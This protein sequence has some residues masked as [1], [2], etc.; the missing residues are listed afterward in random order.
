[1]LSLWLLHY[2]GRGN[3]FLGL[4]VV[5]L[6]S[7]FYLWF[8]SFTF[9]YVSVTKLMLS[10]RLCQ[11]SL[12]MGAREW[13]C[14]HHTVT[15]LSVCVLIKPHHRVPRVSGQGHATGPH[16]AQP[17]LSLFSFLQNRSLCNHTLRCHTSP[18]H[19]LV[20]FGTIFIAALVPYLWSVFSFG[21]V[22]IYVQWRSFQC[23]KEKCVTYYSRV[24]T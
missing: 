11:L 24:W 17:Q 20:M 3:I 8:G 19:L 6:F 13:L 18:M 10:F 12:W 5:I 22:L 15:Y 23:S 16:P 2:L 7:F 4:F 21:D 14:V 9:Q 1:M